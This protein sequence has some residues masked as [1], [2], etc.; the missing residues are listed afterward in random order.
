MQLKRRVALLLPVLLLAAACGSDD[1]DSGEA[2]ET[3][4]SE[5]SETT[6]SETTA[7]AEDTGSE[8]DTENP[9]V[10]GV[11]APTTGRLANSGQ[12][13]LAAAEAA[14]EALNE[15]GGILG[16]EVKIVHADDEA[17]PAKT[18]ESAQRLDSEQELDMIIPGITS[19][20]VLAAVDW[21]TEQ[22]LLSFAVPP[23]AQLA[24]TDTA[25]FHFMTSYST[26]ASHASSI[27]ML[28]ELGVESL[29]MLL[30]NDALG[31]AIE[32]SFPPALAEAGIEVTGLEI[33]DP[34]GIDYTSQLNKLRDSDPQYLLIS[35][36]GA[37]VGII[38]D[39]LF[40]LGWDVPVYGGSDI[41]AN[42]LCQLTSED[43]LENLVIQA[44]TVA[45]REGN[46]LGEKQQILADAL[47]AEGVE[48][49]PLNVP[50]G[51][52]DSLLM[53]QLAAERA[54]STETAAL[55]EALQNFSTEAPPE[56]LLFLHDNYAYTAESHQNQGDPQFTLAQAGC[57]ENGTFQAG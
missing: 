36:F 49:E 42:N 55:V 8:L 31:K 35:G 54:Q 16:R 4:V 5:A 53:V 32:A 57:L 37:S 24:T 45:T 12:A 17:D 43:R 23:T 26:P 27:E 15:T 29:A 34:T 33:Y 22:R 41:A 51:I 40:T 46:E 20:S 47:A 44:Y 11:V 9:F 21:L 30:P 14:A 52:Y 19:S 48:S 13:Q 56:G 1:D 2:S 18:L 28:D 3:T 10:I 39:G 7:S 50:A 6:V 38:L 25:P